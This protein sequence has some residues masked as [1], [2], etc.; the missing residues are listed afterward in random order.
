MHATLRHLLAGA[1]AVPAL[2]LGAC[3]PGAEWSRVSE[4]E[5]GQKEQRAVAE[6]ARDALAETL[7]QELRTALADGGPPAGIRV[8]AQR[9]PEI[10]AEVGKQGGVAIGRTSARLRNLA[11]Q[12]PLWAAEAV[13][14]PVRQDGEG[15]RFWTHADG[16]LAALFP[17]LLASHCVMCHGTEEQIAPATRSALTELY[18]DDR[19]TGFAPGDLRGWFWIEVPAAQ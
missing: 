14:A 5:P 13:G 1:L 10:A 16:R 12:P 7:Q 15:P 19:A 8:C 3:S 9:A 18:P 2:L 17:I 6:K 11:N 4:L